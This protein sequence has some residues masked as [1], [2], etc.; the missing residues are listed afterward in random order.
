MARRLAAGTELVLA[1]HNKG[2]LAEIDAMLR[3]YAVNVVS[4]GDL[5]LPEPV[6]D[7]PDFAGNARLKALA[8][9]EASGR[10]AL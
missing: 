4:A 2:K 7:A 8:A 5:G 6:E 1:T 3:P 9:A 10:A